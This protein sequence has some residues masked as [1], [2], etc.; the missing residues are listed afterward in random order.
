MTQ[1]QIFARLF[2]QLEICEG[3]TVAQEYNGQVALVERPTSAQARWRARLQDGDG[4]PVRAENMWTNMQEIAAE[5]TEDVEA[6][7]TR[8]HGILDG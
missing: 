2:L 6:S 1:H 8:L 7:P 4:K 5:M 3:A